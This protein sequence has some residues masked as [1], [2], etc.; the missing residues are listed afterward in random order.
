MLDSGSD[1]S[2]S[3]IRKINDT[4]SFGNISMSSAGGVKKLDSDGSSNLD[5]S[6]SS[7]LSKDNL[8]IRR[9][10]DLSS[11]LDSSQASSQ[12]NSVKNKIGT[13]QSSISKAS[14]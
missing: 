12:M 8:R 6:M 1:N 3:Q 5:S 14:N 2:G 4:S 9:I 11:D 10:T 7:D 13:T